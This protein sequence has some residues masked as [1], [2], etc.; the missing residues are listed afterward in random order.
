MLRQSTIL[1]APAAVAAALLAGAPAAL[2]A[3]FPENPIEITE[4][5]GAGSSSDLTARVVAEGM[6]EALG[7]P[8]VVVNRPGGGGAV[9][10]S[11]VSD[12][13]EAGYDLVWMS[14]SVLTT[15]H[16]GNIDFDHTAFTAIARVC[17]EVPALAVHT[18][19]GW[20]T[21]ED[22]IAAA[23]ER[24]G[25]MKVGISGEGSFTHL[26]SEVLFNAAGI[27]TRYVPYDKGD[28]AAELFAAASTPRCN[29]R[30]S[31][32][33]APMPVICACSW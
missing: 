12:Q 31:S 23:K 5:F 32:S 4:L 11:H 24:P 17:Q 1:M 9:G 3:E 33:R 26:A 27:E 14:D 2:A 30:R 7:V 18:E 29:G 8:V 6:S 22:F 25:E 20:S 10:Y 28:A 16:A 13:P 21:F 15:H 19:S